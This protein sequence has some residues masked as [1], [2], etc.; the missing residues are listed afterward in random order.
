MDVISK[1]RNGLILALIALEV[2]ALVCGAAGQVRAADDTE[3]G[4]GEPLFPSGSPTDETPPSI[5][6]TQIMLVNPDNAKDVKDQ[7]FHPGS[8]KARKD[9]AIKFVVEVSDAGFASSGIKEV[10]INWKSPKSIWGS[11]G[12]LGYVRQSP[13][14]AAI[15]QVKI[16]LHTVG[17]WT[18]TIYAEDNAGHRT[19]LPKITVRVY[20]PKSK[21]KPSGDD[22]SDEDE[23]SA[24]YIYYR[25]SNGRWMTSD[26][27]AAVEDG[28]RGDGKPHKFMG[29]A[30]EIVTVYFRYHR[31]KT[32][33]PDGSVEYITVRWWDGEDPSV[34]EDHKAALK[35][36]YYIKGKWTD[37]KAREQYEELD[38]RT[39]GAS[40]IAVDLFGNVYS[41]TGGVTSV[42]FSLYNHYEVK[43]W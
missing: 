20:E 4:E 2:L 37:E 41:P 9:T 15:Y 3:P 18:F 7:H 30:D 40:N 42:D 22:E 25:K 1:Y 43:V 32:T 10:G 13:S 16:H 19:T 36:K 23:V 38:G 12:Q 11:G 5:K 21:P 8:E 35:R 14:G 29:Q 34:V 31:Y 39:Y 26:G 28:K 33:N 24:S 6:I 17:T 27:N